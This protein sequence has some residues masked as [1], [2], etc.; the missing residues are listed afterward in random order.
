M[1]DQ[2]WKQ[3]FYPQ[4]RL[5]L[6]FKHVFHLLFIQSQLSKP[7]ALQTPAKAHKRCKQSAKSNM[8]KTLVCFNTKIVKLLN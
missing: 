3:V 1:T 7:K 6:W 4:H 2:N 5:N 8:M